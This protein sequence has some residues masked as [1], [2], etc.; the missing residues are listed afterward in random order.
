MQYTTDTNL[1]EVLCENI[2][3]VTTACDT[4]VDNEA[5]H[6]GNWIVTPLLSPELDV[7]ADIACLAEEGC[8]AGVKS[9]S[10]GTIVLCEA[11][12][13]DVIHVRLG[14]L[15]QSVVPLHGV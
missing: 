3:S 9:G 11:Q 2:G 10:I 4:I 14:G 7:L 13:P 15:E 8:N 5:Q 12:G 6:N 1:K